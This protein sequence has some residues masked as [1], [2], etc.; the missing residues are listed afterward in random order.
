V[1]NWC[2]KEGVRSFVSGESV[3]RSRNT[4]RAGVRDKASVMHTTFCISVAAIH[5]AHVRSG[6]ALEKLPL[7]SLGRVK[8]GKLTYPALYDL[9]SRQ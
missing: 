4:I 2:G 7:P 5:T 6:I 3:S 1:I 9:R 8:G